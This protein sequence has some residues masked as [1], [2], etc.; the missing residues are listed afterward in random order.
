MCTSSQRN[1]PGQ[2][3]RVRSAPWR[4]T[5]PEAC[6]RAPMTYPKTFRMLTPPWPSGCGPR[7][8][9]SSSAR[10][11]WSATGRL[12]RELVEG[13]G[14]LPS[15]ILWG[16]PGTGRPRWPDSWPASAG[17]GSCRS[18][19]SSRGSRS[20]GPRSRGA[21]GPPPGRPHGPVHRRDP[22]L[23]QGPARRPPAGRRGRH[24]HPDR[25]DDR[26]PLVRGQRRAA[27]AVPGRSS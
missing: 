10:P 4:G 8:S 25:R 13:E 19:R 17:R 2:D 23:Q 12:V 20:C 16:G 27:V 22:P 21:G 9:R 7:R 5:K 14:P 26:E 11:T 24:G 1:W 6:S 3:T 18:R 15:L